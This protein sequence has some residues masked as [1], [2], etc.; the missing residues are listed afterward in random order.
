[1]W[2]KESRLLFK[3]FIQKN[4]HS[5]HFLAKEF[6]ISTQDVQN[7]NKYLVCKRLQKEILNNPLEMGGESPLL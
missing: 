2:G 3:L 1:M 7:G 6:G 5:T 4:I